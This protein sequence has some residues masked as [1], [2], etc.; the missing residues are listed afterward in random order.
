MKYSFDI[1]GLDVKILRELQ[2]NARVKVSDISRKLGIPHPTVLLRIKQM[3]TKGIISGYRVV[4]DPEKIGK[5]VKALIEFTSEPNADPAEI[6]SSI[7]AMKNVTA[8]YA[9]TGPTD[10]IAIVNCR[11]IKELDKVIFE[12]RAIEGITSTNSKIV[13]RTAIERVGFPL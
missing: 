12:I 5:P 2:E 10:A 3:E 11:D 13:T 7:E 4:L 1:D 6:I 8:L 9:I